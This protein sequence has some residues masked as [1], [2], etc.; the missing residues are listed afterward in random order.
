MRQTS[1]GRCGA[2]GLWGHGRG[3][4]EVV[5]ARTIGQTSPEEGCG[6]GRLDRPPRRRGV[7]GDNWTDLFGALTSSGRC[8]RR[9]VGADNWTDLFGALRGVQLDRLLGSF[10]ELENGRERG[11][12]TRVTAH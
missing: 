7:G 10:W 9:G 2:L 5:W 4:C 6:W 8:G 3:M 12:L 11:M 1:S